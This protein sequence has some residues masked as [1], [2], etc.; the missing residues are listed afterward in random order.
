MK[1]ASTLLKVLVVWELGTHLGHLLRLLPVVTELRGNG[2]EVLLAVPDPASAHEFLRDPQVKCVKCPTIRSRAGS[3]Q[4]ESDVVC[5]ADILVR[6]AYGDEEG[7]ADALSLWA[8]LIGDFRPDVLLI[9]FAPLAMLAARLQKLPAVHLAIGW[10]APPKSRTL[11]IIRPS[12]MVDEASVFEM[13]ASLVKRINRHCS[14]AGVTE[15]QWLSDLY[16]S[17]T[18][19]IAT[20]PETDHFGPRLQGRYIGPL[21]STEF[22][23]VARWSEPSTEHTTRR[24]FVYLQPDRANLAL[25]KVLKSLGARVIAVLPG[26]QAG[27]AERLSDDRIQLYP[28]PVRLAGLLEQADITITNAGHGLIAASLLAGTPLLLIPRTVEQ[29]MLAKRIKSTGAAQVLPLEHVATHAHEAIEQILNDADAREAAKAIAWKY[30]RCT[31]GSVIAQV[32]NAI[33][34]AFLKHQ[35]NVVEKMTSGGPLA[36]TIGSDFSNLW[37]MQQDGVGT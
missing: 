37:S 29:V 36:T 4:R 23:P 1:S 3:E 19:L 25:L 10:E 17:A 35:Q 16:K 8:T 15:L 2:H 14:S 31:Q 24:V 12:K 34:T 22:G 32:V 20:L 7:L 33:E 21:F 9:E 28:H 27:A 18:Q 13:E 5:Y 30:V 26:L 6:Y 11:P